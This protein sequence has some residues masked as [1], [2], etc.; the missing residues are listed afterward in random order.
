VVGRDSHRPASLPISPTTRTSDT[1]MHRDTKL[2]LALAILVMGFAAALCF[3]R[4]PGEQTESLTLQT[5][6]ELDSGIRLGQVKIHTDADRPK[7][8]VPD[9]SE[10]AQTTP[11]LVPTPAEATV[12]EVLP[13]DSAPEP[14]ANSTPSEPTPVRPANFPPEIVVEQEPQVVHH[15]KYTVKPNDTL[16]SIAK[17]QLGAAGKWGEIF[18]AN[19]DKLSGPESLRPQMVLVIPIPEDD[20]T[21]PTAPSRAAIASAPDATSPEVSPAIQAAPVSNSPRNVPRAKFSGQPSRIGSSN[22]PRLQ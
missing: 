21:A 13:A 10:V 15:K 17:E 4:S 7:P 19:R 5:A 16:S 6:Q 12:T 22:A 14:V 11:V 18:A 9:V 20:E 3:P 8:P 2:G 1:P